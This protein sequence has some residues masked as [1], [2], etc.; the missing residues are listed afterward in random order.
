M[1]RA[2]ISPLPLVE[3]WGSAQRAGGMQVG[4]DPRP[5]KRYAFSLPLEHVANNRVIGWRGRIG[6]VE[7]VPME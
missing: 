7:D 2:L 3:P 6:D 1:S 5:Q 4:W